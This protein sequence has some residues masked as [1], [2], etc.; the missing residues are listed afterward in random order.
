MPSNRQKALG[1]VKKFGK[2]YH[3]KGRGLISPSNSLDERFKRMTINGTGA[4]SLDQL[5]FGVQLKL[6]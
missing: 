4:P 2:F 5:I 6:P 3:I 1:Y